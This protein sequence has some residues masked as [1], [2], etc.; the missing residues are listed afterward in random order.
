MM[1]IVLAVGIASCNSVDPSNVGSEG[2]TFSAHIDPKMDAVFYVYGS[3]FV[4][5]D[6]CGYPALGQLVRRRLAEVVRAC[7]PHDSENLMKY[8]RAVKTH[9][10]DMRKAGEPFCQSKQDLI[11]VKKFLE[12]AQRIVEQASKPIDCSKLTPMF[13]SIFPPREP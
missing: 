13:T 11:S 10:E 4:T 9:L 6:A 7:S 12:D 5:D 2:R 8:E 3:T 1:L